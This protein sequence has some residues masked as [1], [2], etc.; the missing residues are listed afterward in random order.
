MSFYQ[1]KDG[2]VSSDSNSDSESENENKYTEY[3]DDYL[4]VA[5]SKDRN[6]KNGEKTFSYNILFG[7]NF[8]QNSVDNGN[9][10]AFFTRN[11]ENIKSICVEA[12][13]L[14]NLYLDPHEVHGLKKNISG[15]ASRLRKIRDL[16]YITMNVSGYQSNI[17]GTNK[18]ISSAS[19]VLIVD[20]SKDRVNNSGDTN[21][22]QSESIAV[23][24]G[25]NLV[26]GTD[27]SI[28]YMRNITDWSK[29]FLNPVSHHRRLFEI[30]Q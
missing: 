24:E 23:G 1:Y 30:Y 25:K 14:P 7:T 19:N 13:L 27:K 9:N 12:V 2:N 28:L 26:L 8:N 5:N 6:Y 21:N 16:D 4:L 10:N 17:D 15:F 18:V 20:D 29:N 11:Y 22:G 3:T